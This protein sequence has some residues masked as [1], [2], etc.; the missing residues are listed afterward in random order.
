M[1]YKITNSSILESFVNETQTFQF[2]EKI[3]I[4]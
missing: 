1:I 3:N 4:I 2:G